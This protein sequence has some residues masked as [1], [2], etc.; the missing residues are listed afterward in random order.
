MDILYV[1]YRFPKLSESFVIN[2][3]NELENQGHKVSVFSLTEP[4]ENVFHEEVD[5]IDASIYYAEQ[6][7]YWSLTDILSRRVINQPVLSTVAFLDNPK[8]HGYCLH[9][10][11][12]IG[13]VIEKERGFDQIHAHFAT[14]E[15]LAVPIASSYYQIPCTET[16]H[17]YEIFSPPN[18]KRLK[19]VL[20]EFDHIIV[21]SEYNQKYLSE[22]IGV[23]TEMS[24]VPATTDVKKFRPSNDFVPGRIL[25]VAR[26]VEKKGYP[27]VID[28]V[29]KLI[30][31]GYDIEYHIIG[32]GEDEGKIREQVRERGIESHVKFL[33]HVSDEKLQSELHD[34]ELFVLP[35]VIA[36]NGD[37]DVA[38]VALKEAMATQTA[39][40]STTI[41]AIPELITHDVN[42]IL[43][44]PNDSIALF[45]AI[46]DLRQNPDKRK[47]IEKRGRET[48]SEEF[49][50]SQ[51]VAR[52]VRVFES[53][54][55]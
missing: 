15:N 25:T 48:V 18:L 6:P 22:Q 42:G 33:G 28:A 37:R 54:T 47:R 11:T 12:Q 7:T 39:C 23:D 30:E 17:A 53:T 32:S 35:C 8:Y 14:P 13:K 50:I 26:L 49:N 29:S 19:I 34:A 52:L 41:S 43:V 55:K 20:S 16:A 10:S 38:P 51:T 4:S 27:Y 44:E 45:E 46:Q 9:I 2:E 31:Q 3:I 40:I 21:P 36:A 24:I 5:S 1:T